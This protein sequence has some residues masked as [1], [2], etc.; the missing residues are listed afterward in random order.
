M[1]ARMRV[2]SDVKDPKAEVSTLRTY[3]VE[4]GKSGVVAA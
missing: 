3:A 4:A 2:V 1:Q